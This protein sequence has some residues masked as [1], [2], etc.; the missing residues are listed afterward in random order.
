MSTTKAL[1]IAAGVA[2]G[3]YVVLE[4]VRRPSTASSPSRPPSSSTDYSFISGLVNLGKSIFD[5][6]PTSGPNTYGPSGMG[7][8]YTPSTAADFA[9]ADANYAYADS[10]PG[11]ALPEGVFGPP[12][13]GWTS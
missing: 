12:V 2:V 6:A 9:A 13:P 11:T 3:A 5:S 7:I 10:H 4:V 8:N 1:L